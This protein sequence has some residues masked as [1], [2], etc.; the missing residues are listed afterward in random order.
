MS[1]HYT[2]SI[3]PGYLAKIEDIVYK[4]GN[5]L[6]FDKMM[7]IY[8]GALDGEDEDF[9]Y[10]DKG[11][12]RY[13]CTD[14]DGEE[15]IFQIVGKGFYIGG[16][17]TY[18]KVV[19]NKSN[20]NYEIVTESRCVI[21]KIS[22]KN[23]IKLV[24]TNDIFANYLYSVCFSYIDMLANNF[25]GMSLSS[26]KDRLYE[27]LL[28]NIDRK[29][30]KEGNWYELLVQYQR[31]DLAKIIGSTRVTITNIIHELCEED[32]IRVVNNRIEVKVK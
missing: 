5:K 3:N 12:I 27:L 22:K 10:I 30:I 26:C 11:R 15:R 13:V 28:A 20:I 23:L 24:K 6:E 9:Y 8:T 18:S 25:F 16:A 32:L 17:Y 21:Y 1:Y 7:P 14:I 2:P 19:D 31:Q 4:N 29:S